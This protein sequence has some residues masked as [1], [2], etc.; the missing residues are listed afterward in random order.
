VAGLPLG[1]QAPVLVVPVV[2]A[3]GGEGARG[4]E[5]GAG[6]EACAHPQAQGLLG[7][8]W[9]A[10]VPADAV[11]EVGSIRGSITRGLVSKGR[12][13]YCMGAQGGLGWG[14]AGILLHPAL[15]GLEE[16]SC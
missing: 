12:L 10:L 7:E 16:G 14:V 9:L 13:P 5:P 4:P 11:G 6:Q 1:Q 15:V 2:G 8:P 3:V